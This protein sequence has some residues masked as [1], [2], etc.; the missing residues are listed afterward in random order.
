MGTTTQTSIATMSS[1]S[2]QQLARQSHPWIQSPATLN[3]KNRLPRASS[4]SYQGWWAACSKSREMVPHS[5]KSLT[6]FLPHF[7]HILTLISY[8][9]W[10]FPFYLVNPSP[11]LNRHFLSG[12]LDVGIMRCMYIETGWA[13]PAPFNPYPLKFL[14]AT[15]SWIN[16]CWKWCYF[17][18]ALHIC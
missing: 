17:R 8:E 11:L 18:R 16:C 9:L 5:E 2:Q 6:S 1:P 15:A 12:R 14:R 7:H 3:R 4:V 13:Y 10:Y